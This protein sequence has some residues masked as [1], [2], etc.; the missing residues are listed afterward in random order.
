MYFN[1]GRQQRYILIMG[2]I[3]VT[4]SLFST[5][6]YSKIVTA[7][8]NCIVTDIYPANDN[9]SFYFQNIEVRALLQLI[10][11]N[12]G[13][14]FIISNAVKGN[15][16]LNLKNVTWHQALKVI[17]QT[18]GL[19]SHQIGNVIYISTIE[20]ITSTE[21]KQLQSTDALSNLQPLKSVLVKL[22]YTNAA[23]LATVLKG[24]QGTLLTP[25]GQLGVDPRTNSIIIRDTGRN[26][27]DIL[28][29]I[30]KLDIPA[31]QVLI[32]ARIVNI[33]TSYE[34]ELGVRFGLSNSRQLSG[35][36]AGANQ[37]AQ[38]IDVADVT[39]FTE[40]LN[41][42]IPAN[43]LFDGS[44]PGSIAVALL[45]LGSVMLDLELSALEG[46][47][48]AEVIARPRVVTSN[49]TKAMIETGQEIPYQEATSSGAT[50]IV[51]KNAVLSLEIIPQITP[52]DKIILSM[53]ATEDTV[54]QNIAVGA[55]TTAG[56]TGINQPVNIPAINTESVQSHVLL[57]DNETVVVGGVYRVIKQNTWDRIPFF[58]TLP[59]IGPLFTHKGIHNEK[60]EL[61]IFLTPKIIH[62]APPRKVADAC[63]GPMEKRP[64]VFKGAG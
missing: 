13:L 43:Q 7:R 60:H 56:S 62:K 39:P 8:N 32:E 41:F 35:T 23:E 21:S 2:F 16:T 51:F 3:A 20:D 30:R 31:R 54:G 29:E 11:K 55:S 15:V 59:I 25:R 58:G 42:N 40:R 4:L 1:L 24:Q 57:K 17:L 18:Q 38:G 47:R 44:T 22:K 12:S 64:L 34:E 50:A 19:A 48:H 33:D 63:F 9:L 28:P 36:L 52:D 5:L 26:I 6:A 14:N 49:Q 46:E 61:L 10:A 45:H 37:L 53:K 27:G